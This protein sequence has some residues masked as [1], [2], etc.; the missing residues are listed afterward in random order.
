ME[1]TRLSIELAALV[2]ALSIASEQSA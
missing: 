2:I 1:D